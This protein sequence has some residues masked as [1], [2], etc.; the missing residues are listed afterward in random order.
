MSG[1]RVQ[2]V[3]PA[4]LVLP[5]CQIVDVAATIDVEQIDGLPWALE[6]AV[7]DITAAAALIAGTWATI[8]LPHVGVVG[9]AIAVGWHSGQPRRLRLVG[10]GPLSAVP[11]R[12]RSDLT[13]R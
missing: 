8:T 4:A 3:G 11:S 13:P 6:A 5:D 9:L 12:V 7:D 10:A 1:T 2:Y